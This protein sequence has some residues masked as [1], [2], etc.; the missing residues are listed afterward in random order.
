MITTVAHVCG[1][2]MPE[3]LRAAHRRPDRRAP[4]G[5]DH[6]ARRPGR[7]RSRTPWWPAGRPARSSWIPGH[8]PGGGPRA[9]TDGRTDGG[10]AGRRRARGPGVEP[11]RGW[12]PPAGGR[13]RRSRAS[14]P[15]RLSRPALRPSPPPGRTWCSP[16]SRTP[17]C[18]DA[19]LFGP[20]RCHR[21]RSARARSSATWAPP[22]CRR[23]RSTPGGWTRCGVAFVDAPVSG[24][25]PAVR[26]RHPVGDGRR[27]GRDR[28][29]R[30][31]RC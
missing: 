10:S 19:V 16:C 11:Q 25:V 5:P 2:D 27:P 24:S 6:R 30:S 8:E 21:P 26:G 14:G 17:R 3:A 7:R 31:S 22:G 23:S 4:A 20:E 12:T 9:R 29:G 15:C 13:T 18:S 28:S 1:E